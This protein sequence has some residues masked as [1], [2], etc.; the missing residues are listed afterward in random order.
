MIV[1]MINEDNSI[2]SKTLYENLTKAEKI[3]SI[4]IHSQGR[5]TITIYRSLMI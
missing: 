3:R 1:I 5:H 4:S 2:I